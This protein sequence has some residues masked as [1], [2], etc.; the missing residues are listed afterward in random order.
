MTFIGNDLAIE[1]K[2]AKKIHPKHLKGLKALQEE[3]LI[4]NFMV[5]SLDDFEQVTDEG[6]ACLHWSTFLKR[7]WS[8]EL[9]WENLHEARST[10]SYK[11]Y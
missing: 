5:V 9:F 4:K 6:I 10:P 3:N 11:I 7:L 8:G 2:S 1:I